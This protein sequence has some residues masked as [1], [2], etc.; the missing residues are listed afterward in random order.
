MASNLNVPRSLEALST[1]LNA[2]GYAIPALSEARWIAAARAML[3]AFYR[4]ETLDDLP[5]QGLAVTLPVARYRAWLDGLP[6]TSRDPILA[7]WGDPARHWSV[8]TVD[9]LA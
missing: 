9:G 7:R 5:S 4:H 6:A 1:D 8:R 2:A 3:G